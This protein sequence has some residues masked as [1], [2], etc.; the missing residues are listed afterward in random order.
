MKRI[1]QQEGNRRP[2]GYHT[3]SAIYEL[4][5]QYYISTESGTRKATP[6]ELKKLDLK[7]DKTKCN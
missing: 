4:N 7:K 5:G 1:T 3:G 6:A 2:T